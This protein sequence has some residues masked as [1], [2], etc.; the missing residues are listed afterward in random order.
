[1]TDRA[2][3]YLVVAALVLAS[4]ALIFGFAAWR[5]RASER[6][7]AASSAREDAGCIP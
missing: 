1:M 5:Q 3:Q 4:G 7:N 2:Q 6:D